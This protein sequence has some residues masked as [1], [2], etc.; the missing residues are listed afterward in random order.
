MKEVLSESGIL[1]T[2]DQNKADVTGISMKRGFY[3]DEI[4]HKTSVTINEVGTKFHVSISQ[5]TNYPDVIPSF[6]CDHHFMFMI[7]ETQFGMILFHGVVVDPSQ[8]L[9]REKIHTFLNAVTL[10]SI[11]L[12][13]SC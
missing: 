13:L 12:M 1:D 7:V 11:W 3:L 5:L 9:G 6:L 8:A 4:Y 10:L 2:F